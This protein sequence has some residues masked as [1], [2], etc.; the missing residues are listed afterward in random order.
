M[1]AIKSN[2]TL[3]MPKIGIRPVVDGRRSETF[4]TMCEQAM[5]MANLVKELY[6][7]KLLL[8]TGEMAQCV[9]ADRC[10]DGAAAENACAEQFERSGVGVVVTVTPCWCYGTE[11]LCLNSRL[12]QAIWGL[13]A[14]EL[15]GAVFLAAALAAHNQLGIPA[16]QI[17]G[18]DVQDKDDNT[19]PADVEEKLLRFA[20]AGLAVS[21]MR[22]KSYLGIG[23]TSMG[24]AGSMAH[25]NFMYHYLGMLRESI[26]MCE[27]D[28]RMK[29]GIYDESEYTKALEWTKKN[30]KQ[31]KDYNRPSLVFPQE[32]LERIWE[33]TVKMTIIIRDLM[34]GNP[35]LAE[36]GYEEEANGHN[37][38]AGGFQG[39]RQWTDYRPNGDFPE[40]IL[41]SSFDWN[42]IRQ[43]YILATE[44][45]CLNGLTMLFMHLL[46]GQA[47]GFSDIRTYW[48]KE[49]AER[50]G[51]EKLEGLASLGFIHLINS[52]TTALDATGMQTKDGTPVMKHYTQISEEEMQACLDATVWSP[53]MRESFRGGGFSS[54]FRTVG[55]MPVTMA[56]LNL[57]EGLGPVLQIAE[58]WTVDLPEK[59]FEAINLRTDPAWPSTFFVPRLTDETPFKSVYSVMAAWGANHGAFTYGHIG[60]DLITM[61]SM[62]RIPVTMH[63]VSDE[64]IFRPSVWNSFGTR[65]AESADLAACKAFGSLY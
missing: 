40:A 15:P 56:R 23:T 61:A 12:P 7:N 35:K 19:I 16:F 17:Y 21:A 53:A 55:G 20:K 46:T 28:R 10:I 58:G 36:L 4:I 11:V 27:I 30:C 18:K 60:A 54:T 59:T 52:G 3:V 42:G 49:S 41:C 14:T 50:V 8:P 22:G 38:I 34:V 47:Q 31:G 45:D 37:A 6:E 51:G 5:M 29:L 26:D 32:K 64:A 33:E 24:I 62:L 39:Q 57:V 1:K 48:S 2:P 13:N 25:E 63:N 44:N 65:N 43:P 9:I